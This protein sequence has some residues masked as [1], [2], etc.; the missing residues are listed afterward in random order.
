MLKHNYD[1]EHAEL[2]D[3]YI[4]RGLDYELATQVSLQLM[5]HDAIGAHA[6]DEIGI[7]NALSAKPIMAAVTS[8]ISFTI[9]G[10][11]PLLA[12]IAAPEN[13]KISVI[14]SVSLLFLITLGAFAAR[15]GG[16]SVLRGATRVLVWGALAMGVTSLIGSIFGSG[17]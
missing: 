1:S 15:A 17:I 4:K 10:V 11:V 8:S 14:A 3:I 6:R 2:R 7:T 13:A 9:G 16:A 5:A 12:D